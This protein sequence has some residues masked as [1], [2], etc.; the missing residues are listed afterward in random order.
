MLV[1]P[2]MS[3]A[4]ELQKKIN[5]K[6]I[7]RYTVNIPYPYSLKDAQTFI[8]K[9]Q[10]KLR[11]KSSY[12][13]FI[14][15]NKDKQ[16]I[17]GIGFRY[18]DKKNRNG[19]LGC[20][21]NKSFWGRGY[22]KEATDLILDFVFKKL[23]AHRVYAFVLHPN[24]ASMRVLEKCGFKHEGIQRQTILK[25]NCWLDSHTFAILESEYKLIK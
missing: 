17:G 24:K 3:Y 14:V 5:S 12:S 20:W 15:N 21:I 16:L 25:D 18:D 2:K 9:T 23:K 4:K 22:A 11:K 6:D 1:T 10:Y 13:F 8:R 7:V 19:E